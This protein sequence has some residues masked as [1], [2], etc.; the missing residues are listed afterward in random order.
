MANFFYKTAGNSSPER[1][2]RIYFT[3]H[4]KDFSECFEKICEDIFKTHNCAIFYTENMNEKIDE[5]YLDCDLGQM[6]LFV[7]P[8][9]EKL[10]SQNNR[11]MDFDF[12]Y[13]REKHIPI[14]PIMMEHGLIDLYSQKD[15]FGDLQYLNPCE[16]DST[17][18]SY[19]EKL[20]RYL[21][22]VLIGNDTA[23]RSRKAFDAYIFLSYR[24][25]DRHYANQLIKTIHDYP[26]FYDIAIWFDEFL[27]PGED[28]RANIEKMMK[29]SKLVVLLV[30]PSIL[31]YVDGKPN[32]VM[33]YEYPNAKNA[34][35]KVVPAE[36]EKTDKNELLS[37][38]Q[39]IPECIRPEDDEA[40]KARLIEALEK[41]AVS[42]NNAT[43]DH[44]FLMGLAYLEGI[45]VEVNRPKGAALIEKAADA[46]L[47]PAMKKMRELYVVGYGVAA[48]YHKVILWQKKIVHKMQ[49]QLECGDT[50]EI[51]YL[52]EWY[53][54]G[55][56][57][58]KAGKLN[59]AWE[60]YNNAANEILHN[61]SKI[62]YE[63]EGSDL[64]V[65]GLVKAGDAACS[66]KKS[67][68]ALQWYTH[69]QTTVEKLIELK[70]GR[71][72]DGESSETDLIFLLIHVLKAFAKAYQGQAAFDKAEAY[73]SEAV[74]KC[75]EVMQDKRLST[76]QKISA[77]FAYIRSAEISFDTQNYKQA[78]KHYIVAISLL[79]SVE[80]E[81]GNGA[82]Y[83]WII[84]LYHRL[85]TVAHF[86]SDMDL[87]AFYENKAEALRAVGVYL[88]ESSAVEEKRRLAKHLYDQKEYA[89]AYEIY[90]ELVDIGD[91][92]ALNTLALMYRLGYGVDKNLQTAI[93]FYEKA[94]AAG[95]GIAATTLG[96]MYR[97]GE[98]GE[99][100]VQMA[101]N[102]FQRAMELGD[103]SG[104]L[105]YRTLKSKLEY[106]EN[107]K[108]VK[109]YTITPHELPTTGN[110]KKIAEV[111]VGKETVC[112]LLEK[113]SN[114]AYLARTD[115][116]VIDN[117]SVWAPGWGDFESFDIRA[118]GETLIVKD[119][120]F[121]HYNRYTE[122]FLYKYRN[123]AAEE[124]SVE[125]LHEEDV[126]GRTILS[127]AATGLLGQWNS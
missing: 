60:T 104:R 126:P 127:I 22:T 5:R 21:N 43:P 56:D 124:I 95:S 106:E 123:I 113:E 18:I 94:I 36:M 9:T 80:N 48:D 17:A 27:T 66:I 59:E 107:K 12:K 1:K 34:G 84:T 57:Y 81:I 77:S 105:L 72:A 30:T 100:N 11:A 108:N 68:E 115:G 74:S 8:V 70:E 103:P 122:I 67:Q 38:Y 88:D 10:L 121:C 102:L 54:L 58:K 37:K 62:I 97:D 25:K 32:F 112:M 117:F 96:T 41:I 101:L 2:P 76:D 6:N 82:V 20:K 31:E 114:V 78:E 125:Q 75:E 51:S 98:I 44:I 69:A 46:E 61:L 111:T 42:E 15:K 16:I 13:A 33:M 93:A 50:D 24:K 79:E 73:I 23:E 92:S 89:K 85:S 118:D 7:F 4:P 90:K 116:K 64:A 55:D 39:N 28:F 35:L 45:D 87:K 63:P 91:I 83:P 40:F 14:L 110:Y 19:E 119:A 109:R 99:I 86:L 65:N 49:A 53:Q 47:I 29:A 71:N 3:C 52:K 120:D 26:E